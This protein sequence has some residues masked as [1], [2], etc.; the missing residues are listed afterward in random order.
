MWK[1]GRLASHR[2]YFSVSY[3]RMSLLTSNYSNTH[4]HQELRQIRLSNGSYYCQPLEQSLAV[5]VCRY[6]QFSE[7]CWGSGG[8]SV[9]EIMGWFCCR[10]CL[11][12]EQALHEAEG[13]ISLSHGVLGLYQIYAEVAMHERL[14]C[15]RMWFDWLA[16]G[17]GDAAAGIQKRVWQNA[18]SFNCFSRR[19]LIADPQ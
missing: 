17:H 7:S 3:I 15:T 11:Q 8:P 13:N 10:R 18:H 12:L 2:D 19:T 16:R 6:E 14:R 9:W 1:L 5:L 4:L